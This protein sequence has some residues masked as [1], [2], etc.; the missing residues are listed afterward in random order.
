MPD[1]LAS[2]TQRVMRNAEGFQSETLVPRLG[3]AVIPQGNR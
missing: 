1:L 2:M 3:L